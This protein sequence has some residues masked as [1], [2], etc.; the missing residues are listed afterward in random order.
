LHSAAA[1]RV[2]LLA[3]ALAVAVSLSG[4]AG[5]PALA[6]HAIT[7]NS[8]DPE[9]DSDGDGLADPFEQA[10]RL[11]PLRA[12]TDADGLLDPGEDLDHDGLSNLAEQTF[13]TNPKSRDSDQDGT[14]DAVDDANGDGIVDWKQQD[15]RPVPDPLTPTLANANSDWICYRPGV[16]STGKCVGDPKGLTRVAIYGDSHAGMWIPALDRYAKEHHWRL[17]GI[18]RSGCPSVHVDTTANATF[19][20]DC[21]KWRQDSERHL[22]EA[23]PDLVIITNYSH[24]GPTAAQWRD[25]LKAAITKLSPASRVL[26]LADTPLFPHKVPKC[27]E[28]HPNNV[29]ACDVP[30]ST[31]LRAKHDTVEA[32]AAKATGATFASMNPWV[33]PVLLC[34]VVVGHLLMWRDN[35]HLTVTY[36]RQL[37]EALGALLPADL[38]R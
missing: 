35:H 37:A 34:P 19:N 6:S 38:P 16:G 31:G 36:A 10:A 7:S 24:Y 27:L 15:A 14:P 8:T 17:Q 21:R 5:V 30:R 29:G 33:C 4:Q 32:D 25:G 13:G 26:V 11:D 12:D 1:I 20:A 3:A 18:A 9:P 2:A 23:P 28:N 22:R